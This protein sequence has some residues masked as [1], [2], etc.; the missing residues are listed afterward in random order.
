MSITDIV[1]VSEEEK[2]WVTRKWISSIAMVIKER[3]I[4]HKNA[5]GAT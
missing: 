5:R 1:D 2:R 3:K 4:C